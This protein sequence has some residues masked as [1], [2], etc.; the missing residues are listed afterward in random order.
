MSGR[1]D[2]VPGPLYRA[3]LD[4]GLM[5]LDAEAAHRISTTGLRALAAVPGLAR[6]GARA[7]G[8][9][10]PR[11]AV[12]ALGLRFPGPLGLAAGFDKDAST[13]DGLAG[14]GFAFV[15]VG[16]VTARSQP[17]NPR[18]RLFRLE[19]DLAIVNRMG[20]NNSGAEA[21]TET[22]GRR[23]ARP[24]VPVVVGVNIGRSKQVP[25]NEA[26]GDYATSARLLAPHADYLVVNV[27]SPNTAGLRDLQAV[28]QLRPLLSAVR[29][30]A[31]DG[32]GRHVPLLVKIAPDLADA[33]VLAVAELA[34]ELGL[35]GVVATNTT[36]SRTG[37]R[38]PAE[39]VAAL[40]PGGLSGPVLRERSLQVLRLVRS[41]AGAG[42]VLVSVG[43][44]TTA[45]D[46]WQR[47]RA[48]ATLVQ[49]YGGLVYG[50]PLWPSRVHRGLSAR[51]REHGIGSLVDAVG[52]DGACA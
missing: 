25:A 23:R 40:G 6:A 5:R 42:L 17:G 30:A 33:D 14:L 26:V 41:R 39:Q 20:F 18:P 37:L 43:G 49:A 12:E 8:P 2:G 28:E 44:I 3:V 32:A 4:G 34:V 38:T 1:P 10:D 51:L 27:S 52:L 48:G 16:T 36:T 47:I 22:L 11:L 19:R 31:D 9:H 46:A 24:H 15:E 29:T 7:M 50:G 21:V 35:D 45:D 13:V